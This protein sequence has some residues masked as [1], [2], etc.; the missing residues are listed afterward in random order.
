MSTLRDALRR[1]WMVDS[2]RDEEFFNL[3]EAFAYGQN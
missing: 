3:Y 1:E 2:D